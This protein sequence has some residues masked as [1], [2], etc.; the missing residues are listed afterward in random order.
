MHSVES[1][2]E[3]WEPLYSRSRG[4][5]QNLDLEIAPEGKG[6]TEPYSYKGH[7]QSQ[8]DALRVELTHRTSS[9]LSIEDYSR[10]TKIDKNE[11]RL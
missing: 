4:V 6:G 2:R 1:Q 3:S 9:R 10:K 11:S 5:G 7:I 8:E